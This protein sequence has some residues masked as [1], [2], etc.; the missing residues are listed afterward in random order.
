MTVR[1]A[2]ILGIGLL[3][4]L[5]MIGIGFDQNP[6]E[7]SSERATIS[8]VLH[9]PIF[10]DD[11]SGF[12]GPNASTGVTWGSGT[13]DDPYIIEGWEINATLSPNWDGIRVNNTNSSF[14]IRQCLI[15]GAQDTG[16][17]IDWG[18]DCLIRDN[19]LID[20]HGGGIYTY[21]VRDSIIENNIGYSTPPHTVARTIYISYASTDNVIANNSCSLN[22]HYG[23]QVAGWPTQRNKIVNNSCFSNNLY[24]IYINSAAGNNS[25]V[26]NNCSGNAFGV[27]SL[28]CD[29]NTISGNNCSSNSING[30]YMDDSA[31]NV[32]SDNFCEG[33][34]DGIVLDYFASNST[35]TGNNCSNN[36]YGIIIFLGSSDNT[37]SGNSLCENTAFGVAILHGI[38]ASIANRIYDNIFI[39]NNGSTGVYDQMHI[40]AYDEETGNWWDGADGYGNW[41]SDW[42]SP[43]VEKPF[44]IVDLPYNISGVAGAKDFFPLT[45]AHVIPDLVPPTTNASV[46]GTVGQSGWYV[47]AAAV[48][49]TANDTGTGVNRT[50][51]SLNGGVSWA[52]YSSPVGISAEGTSQLK[53]YSIDNNSNQ[54]NTLSVTLKIDTKSP[55]TH[56]VV[57]NST[58]ILS[59]EDNTSGV[60]KTYFR[61][62]NGLWHNYTGPITVNS[63]GNHSI[64]FYSQDMA[65]NNESFKTA[66]VNVE[67]TGQGSILDQYGI[68]I[69]IVIIAIM[70]VI[71][72]V[73][74][75]T[76]KH[77]Q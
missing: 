59:A 75:L 66:W 45:N 30:I 73:Y 22:T 8:Y 50:K 47:S 48:T 5:S 27:Y 18:R 11:D 60:A 34:Q 10:I 51:Y 2:T 3:I 17:E 4:A 43:D 23:I 20:N 57:T 21:H 24:G 53:F 16:I 67:G 54:E 32:I 49:L 65:G 6:S 61:V 12:L 58:V 76:R 37:V 55:L 36:V 19:V 33:N 15:Y 38:S 63:E 41:W 13:H 72:V 35:L 64:D 44:G 26:D 77:E 39:R 74:I 9:A 68:Y 25:F 7:N 31:R 42:T 46:S 1:G 70:A 69:I 40:Q 29:W 52:N 56:S 28:G 71:V 62:D 14:I